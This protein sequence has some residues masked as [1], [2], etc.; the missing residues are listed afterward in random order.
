MQATFRSGT[1]GRAARLV[2]LSAGLGVMAGC[3]TGYAV[4]RPDAAGS[5]AYY[6]SDGPYSGPGYDDYHGTGPYYSGTSGYGYY[7]GTDPYSDPFGGYGGYGYWPSVTL[8]LGISNVWDFPGYWGPWY[9]TG[10]AVRRCW[11]RGCG[12]RGQEHHHHHWHDAVA[13]TSPRPWLKPDHALGPSLRARG[14]ERPVQMPE[15]PVER[16]ANRRPLPSTEFLPHGFARG[17][18]NRLSGADFAGVPMPPRIP[19]FANSR[20]TPAARQDFQAALRPAP[21]RP[22]PAVQPAPAA[23]PAAPRSDTPRTKIP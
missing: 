21:F 15:R 14:S 4:V 20:M 22:A 5:G 10:F 16:F 18:V 8:N 7:G 17:S 19:E 11:H 12:H 2:V 9:S 13:A 6:T 1:W 23:R 3:A